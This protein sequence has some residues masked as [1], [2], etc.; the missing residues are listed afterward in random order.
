MIDALVTEMAPPYQPPPAPPIP[1]RPATSVEEEPHATGTVDQAVASPSVRRPSR[2]VRVAVFP[3]EAARLDDYDAI[4]NENLLDEAFEVPAS[5]RLSV[6]AL[7]VSG[8]TAAVLNVSLDNGRR[9]GALNDGAVLPVGAWFR[10]P[11]D[12][13]EGDRVQLQVSAATTL[14]LRCFFREGE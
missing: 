3:V 11:M 1:A 2:A 13:S 6:Q 7:I 8:A 10:E 14:S 5:G 9:F 4:E 12:V